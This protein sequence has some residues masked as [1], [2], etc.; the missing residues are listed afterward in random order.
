ML[1]R[2]FKVA[3]C[4]LN[5]TLLG[6][7]AIV[8]G[9]SG[10]GTIGEQLRQHTRRAKDPKRIASGGQRAHHCRMCE[11]PKRSPEWMRRFKYLSG[12]Q[13]YCSNYIASWGS[14]GEQQTRFDQFEHCE[15]IEIGI[16]K[17]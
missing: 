14:Q 12:V 2:P 9:G 17:R 13:R 6:K 5:S 11:K 10:G 4:H 1:T 15:A 7:R 8:L 16:P 3:C